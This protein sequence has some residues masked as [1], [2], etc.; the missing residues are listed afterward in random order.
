MKSNILL[1]VTVVFFLAS[2][3]ALAQTGAGAVEGVVTDSSGAVI[4]KAAI[5][6]TNLGTQVRLTTE[7]NALGYYLFAGLLPGSYR[8][9]VEFAGMGTR[10]ATVTIEA[11]RRLTVNWTLQPA[12][13]IMSVDVREVV[14]VVNTTDATLSQVI[15]RTRIDQLPRQN[16]Q[17]TL[18]LPLVPGFEGFRSSGLR[19]GSTDYL[20]DG[21]PLLSRTRGT[22][23]NRQPGLDS[24]QEVA[25]EN[26]N[27]SAKYNSPV[28]MVMITRSGT[29]SFHGSAFHTHTNSRVGGARQRQ[30]GDELAPFSNRGQYGVSGGG[31]LIRNRTFW[32]A[33]WEANREVANS[34][35]SFRVPTAAMREGD[36]SGLRDSANRLLALYDPWTTQPGT[37]QR[38]PFAHG[39]VLNRIDPQRASPL[40]RSLMEITPLPTHPDANPVVAPN[41]IGPVRRIGDDW[42]LATRLDHRLSDRDQLS[43][44]V[45]KSE[46]LVDT[47]LS[48]TVPLLD[49]RANRNAYTSPAWS[50][51]VTWNRT[52]SLTFFNEFLSSVRRQAFFQ[53]SDPEA[54]GN[55]TD[56][57][58][59]PNPMGVR[60]FPDILNM[61]LTGLAYRTV[62]PNSDMST[63]YQIQDNMTKIAGRHE[64]QFGI[65]LRRDDVN[66]MPQQ[67][68]AAGL[69][70]PVTNWTALWDPAGSLQTPRALPLTGAQIGSAF[71][72]SH[73][74]QAR[75]NIPYFYIRAYQTALYFQ[76]NYRVNRRLTLNLG[77]RWAVWPSIRERNRIVSSFDPASGSIVLSQPLEDY[78][79]HLPW[80]QANVEA[81]QRLGVAFARYDEVGLPPKMMH[82]NWRNFGPRLGFA[83][84][85]IGDRRPLVLRA[86]LS[87]SYFPV[88]I[89]S[90]LGRLNSSVP[91]QSVPFWNPDSAGFWPDGFGGWSLR[92]VPQYVAGQNT[93]DILSGA[94]VTGMNPGALTVTYF[95]PNFPDSRVTEW[96][97]TLEKE[98]LNRT[99]ARITWTGNMTRNLDTWR[100]IN[101]QPSQFVWVWNTL[102]P[103]P[104]GA[105]ATRPYRSLFGD[106]FEIGRDGYS[107]Y[108]GLQ[109][110]LRRAFANGFSYDL[111]YVINNALSLGN[112]GDQGTQVTLLPHAAYLASQV[113]HLDQRELDR[114]VNYA[115]DTSIPKQRLTFNWVADIPVGKGRRFG[116]HFN[117]LAQALAGGWQLSGFYTWRTTWFSLPSGHFPTGAPLEFYGKKYPIQDCRSGICL[118]GFLHF[119][120]YLNPLQINSTDAQGRPNGVMGVPANYRPAFAP[121]ITD[122]SSPFFLTNNL[123]LTLPNGQTF[124]ADYGGLTPLRNQFRQGPGLWSLSS[125]LF[126]DFELREPVKLRF[127]WDV[128]N[129]TNSPQLPA[130]VGGDGIRPVWTSGVAARS[131][132]LTLRLL[133]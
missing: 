42:T 72:G 29:N 31:P 109:M 46:M 17:V 25:V 111:F 108:S 4:P 79:R 88:Q 70:Q 96:N 124:R 45:S 82:N 92:T 66:H 106:V 58:G 117:R 100:N 49:N 37:F 75:T 102:T 5:T 47:P 86:G 114:F 87:V 120:G 44:R 9:V 122:P 41:W 39:G 2:G 3:W 15:D 97:V 89:Q 43:V 57:L 35:G 28:A 40:W 55:W 19:Y 67:T 132:Q 74:Y 32:F 121:L 123:I 116:G 61:G 54:R 51:A 76:D 110:Q 85:A 48:G 99:Q 1:A 18:L 56:Q 73:S 16:R 93:R 98:V 103:F 53:S 83:Y 21:A 91:F 130:G 10:E 115:R 127:Q 119:N 33:S 38:Q 24:L 14:P 60:Q 68:Q 62:Y 7:T 129:P 69:T 13:A 59:L 81:L 125:A 8:L 113:S 112:I 50:V 64:F 104:S 52:F 101:P 90:Q 23:E 63:F 65:H 77:L 78:Y 84:R 20:L 133:W 105:G 27:V 118:E 95:T 6:L 12:E 80:L 30:A 94:V 71:L 34:L 22:I 36:F 126:K 107:N 131:M 26:N 128:F 11:S